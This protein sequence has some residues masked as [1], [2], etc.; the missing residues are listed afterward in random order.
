MPGYNN[1]K[2]L[3]RFVSRNLNRVG[4]K[5][6]RI[7]NFMAGDLR[8]NSDCATTTLFPS[9]AF[10]FFVS[11]S[12]GTIY[13]AY[14][15]RDYYTVGFVLFE[16]SAFLLLHLCLTAFHK[17]PSQDG[18]KWRKFLQL[19]IWVLYS[20]IVFGFSAYFSPLF[21]DPYCGYSLYVVSVAGSVLLFYVYV[22]WDGS[23][24]GCDERLGE[25]KMREIKIQV[26]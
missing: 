4:A 15:L 11:N 18:T 14:Y 20:A 22:I 1:Q 6:T 8:A 26:Y 25:E 12:I 5:T 17:L 10:F 7:D 13:R 3:R 23:K 21:G 9:M 2:Q 24:S 19:A 16:Y